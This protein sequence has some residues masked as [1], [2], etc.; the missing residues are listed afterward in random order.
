MLQSTTAQPTTQPSQQQLPTP[1]QAQK[2]MKVVT[3]T[4]I[5]SP[6]TSAK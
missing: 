1:P 4:V 3:K 5:Q 6:P 2:V